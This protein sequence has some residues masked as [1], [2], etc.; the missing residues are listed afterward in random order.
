MTR[1]LFSLASLSLI[2]LATAL[3][4]G[5]FIGDLYAPE[6]SDETLVWA[7][8]HRLTGIAAALAVVFVESVIVTYFIGTSRWCK[9]VVDTYSLDQALLRECSSLKRRTFPWALMGM[10][11][12]IGIIALG[13]AA[14]PAS[15]GANTQGWA[16]WHL[17]GAVL[18]I[19]LIAWTYFVA[20][21][22][23]HAN[24]RIIEQIVAQVARV[25]NQR[26]LDLPE[27]VLS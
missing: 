19:M 10:L 27:R 15:G 24:H 22:H 4:L 13:G 6:I 21:N 14:D 8:V 17:I 16:Q 3:V 25:R 9:E 7:T 26:G 1:I 11:A 2:L 20:W 18:G 23:I 5:L 12:V